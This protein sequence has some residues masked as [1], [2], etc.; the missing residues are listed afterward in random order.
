MP[1]GTETGLTY[2]EIVDSPLR[3]GLRVDR[4]ITQ[5]ARVATTSHGASTRIH[6]ILQAQSMDLIR[7]TTHAIRELLGIRHQSASD[8]ITV[9]SHRPTVVENDVLVP[10]V[11]EAQV[12]NG[13]RGLHDLGLVHIAEV[14]VLAMMSVPAI[15]ENINFSNQPMSS[16]REPA[17][18]QRHQEAQDPALLAKQQVRRLPFETC[19]TERKGSLVS[20]SILEGKMFHL[21][22][23][24]TGSRSIICT[25]CQT[26]LHAYRQ[27]PS[28]PSTIDTGSTCALLLLASGERT[29]IQCFDLLPRAWY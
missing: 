4:L 26:Q 10:G 18:F 8:R 2:L 13:I 22:D 5:R 19:L 9:I 21:A 25:G 29:I 15:R 6:A 24:R 16:S 7:G 1:S 27:C 11:L 28:D 3:E 23:S 14:C 12:D 17:V 20:A